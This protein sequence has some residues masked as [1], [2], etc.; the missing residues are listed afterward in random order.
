MD[1]SCRTKPVRLQRGRFITYYNIKKFNVKI[2]K[3]NIFTKQLNPGV[4]I[5]FSFLTS[6][7]IT[8]LPAS[9]YDSLLSGETVTTGPSS[10]I[11]SLPRDVSTYSL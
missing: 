5:P 4:K 9:R 11:M 10:G 2:I 3:K 1:L 8:L 6:L 7:K